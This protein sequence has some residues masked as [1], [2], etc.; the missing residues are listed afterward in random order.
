MGRLN[1]CFAEFSRKSTLEEAKAD[2]QIADFS[3]KLKVLEASAA[4]LELEIDRLKEQKAELLQEAVEAER[5]GLLWE[6]KI[7][8]EKEM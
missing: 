4:A 8:L 5:Q 7:D 6:R 1:D 3:E 2:T